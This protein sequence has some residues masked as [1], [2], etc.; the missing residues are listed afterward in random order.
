MALRELASKETNLRVRKRMLALAFVADGMTPF[1]AA[2]SAGLTRNA[3][4]ASIKR[5]QEQGLAGVRDRNVPGRPR[6][7]NDAQLH[8]LRLALLGRPAM[9]CDQLRDLVQA[10]FHVRYSRSSI[11]RLLK[12]AGIVKPAATFALAQPPSA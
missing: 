4:V 1:A 5:F 8:E 3:V 11:H 7:L 10:R 9:T 12:R 6:K 2:A